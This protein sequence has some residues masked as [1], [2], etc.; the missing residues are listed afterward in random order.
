M[1]QTPLARRLA[2]ASV[3]IGLMGLAA[4]ASPARPEAMALAA[5]AVVPATASDVGYRAVRV[6]AVQGGGETNPMWMSNVSNA[7]FKAALETSLQA[8]NYFNAHGPL[9]VTASMI[10][11][12]RPLAGLDM[13]T[14]IQVRYSVT[15]ASGRV[16]FDDTVSATGTARMGD[17]F[18]G[19]ER[20]RMANEAAVRENIK[21]FI[22]RFRANA[23]R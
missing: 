10:D 21:A 12:Q 15:D 3:C 14:T 19:T 20:L 9:T 6:A 4:C 5:G 17:A 18:I 8:T 23:R 11:L 22:D 1:R 7:E 16:V 2:L 13:S